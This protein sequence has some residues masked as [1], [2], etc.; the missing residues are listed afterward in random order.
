MK[1]FILSL[2]LSISLAGFAQNL[3]TLEH[4][5][6]KKFQQIHY[7]ERNYPDD[8][9]IDRVDSLEKVNL[10]FEDELAAITAKYPATIGYVF[11]RLQDSG[12]IIASSADGLFRIYSW[13]TEEG[14]S[15]HIFSTV[16]Q[17]RSGA[18]VH[19]ILNSGSAKEGDIAWYY[20]VHSFRTSD[21]TYYLAIKRSIFSGQGRYQAIRAF[22]IDGKSLNDSVGLFKK[23]VDDI[24]NEIGF[25]YFNRPIRGRKRFAGD[26]IVFDSTAKSIRIPIISEED[27]TVTDQFINYYWNGTYFEAK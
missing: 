22:R 24:E 25:E 18:K 3:K 1:I 13:D 16:F 7:W 19:S 17:Y 9:K 8:P 12:L 6:S 10:L 26:L 11:Q 23:S 20:P 5:L 4:E 14:G 27:N 21:T 15:M 2:L